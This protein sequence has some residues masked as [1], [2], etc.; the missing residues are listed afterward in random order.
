MKWLGRIID[1]ILQPRIN[2]IVN[3]HLGN[4]YS[5]IDL[6]ESSR[7]SIFAD[8]VNGHMERVKLAV[9]ATCDAFEAK[10]EQQGQRIE[11]QD[12]LIQA[13]MERTHEVELGSG[14]GTM[15]GDLRP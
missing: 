4:H 1:A 12:K 11:A 10:L 6:N 15:G 7:Y 9:K 3:R 8:G 5:L 13:L 14:T 2:V